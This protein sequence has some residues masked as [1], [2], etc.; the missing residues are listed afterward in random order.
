MKQFPSNPINSIVLHK[1]D[2]KEL[3]IYFNGLDFLVKKMHLE[4]EPQKTLASKK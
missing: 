2:I 3:R 1:M 4:I